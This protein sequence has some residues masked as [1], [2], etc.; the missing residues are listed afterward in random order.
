[1]V[2]V[3]TTGIGSV[4]GLGLSES[5]GVGEGVR[6]GVVDSVL[7]TCDVLVGNGGSV[8][9]GRQADIPTPKPALRIRM[10]SSFGSSL[11]RFKSLLDV[12]TNKTSDAIMT[13]RGL[14]AI[15][16]EPSTD[17]KGCL[18]QRVVRHPK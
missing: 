13:I 18:F 14:A 3:I 4:V 8:G 16:P 5:D 7:V 15:C 1:M 12:I 17:P 9:M 10:R 2:V 6:V 11:P